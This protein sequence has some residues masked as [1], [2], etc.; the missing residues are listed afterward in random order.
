MTTNIAYVASAK[1]KGEG[2]GGT[3]NTRKKGRGGLGRREGKGALAAALLFF[4]LRLPS[5][6]P[7]QESMRGQRGT[8]RALAVICHS[9]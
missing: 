8:L 7:I 2:G 1:G 9:H 3:K 6:Y 5:H 4:S